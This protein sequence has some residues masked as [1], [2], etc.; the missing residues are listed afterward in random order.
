MERSSGCPAIDA[1]ATIHGSLNGGTEEARMG[2]KAANR[3]TGESEIIGVHPQIFVTDMERAVAFYRDRL[4]FDVE[5][6]YGDPPHYGLVVRG[7]AGLNLRRVDALPVDA[8][9]RDRE[10]LLAATLVVRHVE[11]LYR[12]YEAA[13][14]TFHQHLR[15]QS[16]GARDFIVADP[17]GNLVH[18]ASPA[19]EP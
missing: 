3:S 5:Y 6:L 15:E 17:D 19:G 14:L 9:M 10:D 2:S 7:R 8:S 1:E 13:G 11:A 16:W 18:F 4:G 12:T